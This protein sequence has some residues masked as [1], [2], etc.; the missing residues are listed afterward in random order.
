[1][2][3]ECNGDSESVRCVCMRP[4]HRVWGWLG[5]GTTRACSS[6]YREDLRNIL[7]S[8]VSQNKV[9]HSAAHSGLYLETLGKPRYH[10]LSLINTNYH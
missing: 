5:G 6:I 2:H 9:R 7:G 1:M 8:R 10:G 4:I 3:I